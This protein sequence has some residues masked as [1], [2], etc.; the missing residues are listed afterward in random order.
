ML[1]RYSCILALA[2]PSKWPFEINWACTA[3]K[4]YYT[5]HCLYCQNRIFD[6]ILMV[7]PYYDKSIAWKRAPASCCCSSIN[8][9]YMLLGCHYIKQVYDIT[10]ARFIMLFQWCT[11]LGNTCTPSECMTI[12]L[13]I[14]PSFC[15]NL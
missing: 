13:A 5:I 3:T 11:H 2:L 1:G 4:A 8:V 7:P 10:R 15:R 9:H 12:P 6:A 14:V